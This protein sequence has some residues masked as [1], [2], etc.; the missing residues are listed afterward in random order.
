MSWT[1]EDKVQGPCLLF[2]SLSKLFLS[3]QPEIFKKGVCLR[4]SFASGR[5]C[6]VHPSIVIPTLHRKSGRDMPCTRKRMQRLCAYGA[7]PNSPVP[8][9]VRMCF[10][11][12][13]TIA[14]PRDSRLLYHVFT[15]LSSVREEA[16][17]P[18]ALVISIYTMHIP[19]RNIIT[20]RSIFEG[21]LALHSNGYT[22]DCLDFSFTS[23]S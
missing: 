2:S 9:L 5:R 3:P 4:N 1:T 6:F 12:Q 21:N 11:I 23:F 18:S 10:K 8:I 16:Y 15:Y 17:V 22:T 13:N 7:F 20:F 19:Y 14:F